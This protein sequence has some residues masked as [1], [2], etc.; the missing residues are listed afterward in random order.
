MGPL[1]VGSGTKTR[2]PVFKVSGSVRE[3]Q[4]TWITTKIFDQLNTKTSII[5]DQN[6][7]HTKGVAIPALDRDPDLDYQPLLDS[8][9]SKK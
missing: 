7:I 3:L 6:L 4:P 9:S 2:I 5:V 1:K 8:G